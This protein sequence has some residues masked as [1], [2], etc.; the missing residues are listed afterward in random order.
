M[1]I[2]I[3]GSNGW[4]STKTGNTICTL[5][6]T[7]DCYIVLDAGDG[8]NKLDQHIESDVPIFLFLSHFHLDHIIGLHGLLGFQFSQPM[9]IFGQSGTEDFL[10][11]IIRS[12][13]AASLSE[14][15]I[16]VSVQDLS[17]G[18]NRPPITP[19]PVE[20]RYLYHSEPCVGYRFSIEGKTIA[21]C[22]DTGF[23]YSLLKLAKNVDV[24]ITECSLKTGMSG[25]SWPHLTP[26]D[27]A[28]LAKEAK[29]KKLL[30]THFDA[31]HYLSLRER[32]EAGEIAR[33]IFPDTC[34]CY[35]GTEIEI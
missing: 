11:K 14:L 17:V 9:K 15:K 20:E 10:N 33:K 16:K 4:Y 34:V 1:K 27:G 19:F 21:Y 28:N 25:K 35:D 26:E 23:C 12:P 2:R 3:L 8:L 24:L 30:L 22:T 6:E 18:M 7:K 29:V 13:F 31:R 32:K 5:I